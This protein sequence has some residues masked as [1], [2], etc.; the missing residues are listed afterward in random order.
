MRWPANDSPMW[1]LVRYTVTV[2][3]VGA[4]MHLGYKNGF[5]PA[6]DI[7]G[8]LVLLGAAGGAEYV[9]RKIAAKSK[10]EP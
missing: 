4:W 7:P 5:D 8:L 9:Q 6:K 2:V 10:D 1:S 3:A